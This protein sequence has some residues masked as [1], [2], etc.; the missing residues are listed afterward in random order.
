[1]EIL[2]GIPQ[3]LQLNLIIATLVHNLARRDTD[4]ISNHTAGPQ[5]HHRRRKN[6]ER[7]IWHIFNEVCSRSVSREQLVAQ[8]SW[9]VQVKGR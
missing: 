9:E 1:M 2:H 6:T 8:L 4:A 3:S 5:C 7:N